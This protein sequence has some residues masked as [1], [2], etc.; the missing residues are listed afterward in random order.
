MEKKVIF[1]VMCQK[2]ISYFKSETFKRAFLNALNTF[3]NALWNNIKDE[4]HKIL[5]EIITDIEKYVLSD[6]AKEKEELILDKIMEKLEL[7]IILKPLRGLIR[8]IIKSRLEE[9]I[10][11]AIKK[12]K[13]IVS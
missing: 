2:F 10:I 12:S 6:Q 7:P 5:A 8:K 11:E 1:K 9:L 4:V 3:K 13:E